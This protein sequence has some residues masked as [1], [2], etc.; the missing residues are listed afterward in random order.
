MVEHDDI[1]QLISICCDGEATS[2]EKESVENHVKTC[3][4]CKKYQ[5]DMLKLSSSLNSWT[6]EDLSPDSEQKIKR[7]FSD[8]KSRE[9]KQMKTQNLSMKAGLLGSMIVAL[10]VVGIAGMQTYSQR[11]IQARVRDA[12]QYLA[13]GSQPQQVIHLA[14]SKPSSDPIKTEGKEVTK[15][16]GLKQ[17]EPYSLKSNYNVSGEKSKLMYLGERSD[18]EQLQKTGKPVCS[19][20]IKLQ[21]VLKHK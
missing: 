19:V 11:V 2:R 18:K 5:Q 20:V 15:L 12:S 13:K 10:I 7:N 21:L 6:D 8:I 9:G 17:Y 4:S 1:K 14:T 3:P 16:A